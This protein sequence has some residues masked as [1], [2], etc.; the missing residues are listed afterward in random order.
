LADG[1]TDCATDAQ[2][3]PL[4]G[5]AGGIGSGKSTVA[6]LLGEFGAA[7]IESDALN[8][9]Q[10]RHPEVIA[11][12]RSWWGEE[13][14]AADG[15]LD[16]RK[17]AQKIFSDPKERARLE[18]YLHPRIAAV[19]DRLIAAY[20]ADSTYWGI[21]LDTPLLVEA[22]MADACDAVVFVDTSDEIRRQR[23]VSGRGW[24]DEEWR[25]REKSQNALDKKR[26]KADHVLSNNSMD[27]DELRNEVRKLLA[28]LGAPSRET[29]P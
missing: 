21:V 4:I 24:S 27:L 6:K 18:G 11:T 15:G 7:V 19:R 23:V 1:T 13:I 29:L 5:L 25:K 3:K 14:L 2:H 22:G 17:I 9:E 16:K 12:L 20:R 8:S 26:E 28:R 10:L